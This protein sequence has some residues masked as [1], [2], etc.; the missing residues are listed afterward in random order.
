M[1]TRRLCWAPVALSSLL[2]A[3]PL[4]PGNSEPDPGTS[5]NPCEVPES[6]ETFEGSLDFSNPEEI[7]ELSGLTHVTGDLVLNESSFVGLDLPSLR[8]VGGELRISWN[9]EL[10]ALSLPC[11]DSVGD[12]FYVGDNG[13][14]EGID[15]PSL[16]AVEGDFSLVH[17]NYEMASAGFAAL[18]AVGGHFDIANN[19]A[20]LRAEFDFLEAVGG[21]FSL[22][23]LAEGID[24]V[25]SGASYASLRR[26]GGSLL[27]EEMR[28]LE[29]M[30]FE[31]LEEVPDD[32]IVRRNQVLPQ[33]AVEHLL[34]R[35]QGMGQVAGSVQVEENRLDC[36]CEQD[37]G[38]VTVDCGS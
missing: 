18:E 21:D 19:D 27:V 24:D 25:V 15:F 31:A 35:L 14:I 1:K 28:S 3:C 33:C 12:R 17:N 16:R 7:E 2:A 4:G 9:T 30:H 6:P 10:L 5:G 8:S 23:N 22:R 32:F 34:S 11:L 36:V 13:A 37:A 26:I 38:K 29:E 20:L